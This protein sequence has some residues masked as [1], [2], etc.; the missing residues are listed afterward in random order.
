MWT[1]EESRT[2]TARP[3]LV[4]DRWVTPECW[5]EHDTAVRWAELLGPLAVGSTI[6]IR[7]NG[8][9][10]SVAEIVVL[11]PER[12]F[13][14]IARMPGCTLTVIQR[15]HQLGSGSLM[16]HRIELSGLATPVFRRLFVETMAAGVPDVLAAVAGL[17]EADERG[18]TS[19]SSW[20]SRCRPGLPEGR[21]PRSPSS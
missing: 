7:P 3:A 10:A 21:S 2:T 11:E 17:V 9:P 12:H 5:P 4:W 15:V 16:R 20:S 6:R 1:I 8:G 14:T 13:A 19:R 18:L